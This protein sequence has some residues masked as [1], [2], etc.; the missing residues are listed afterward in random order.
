MQGEL[1]SASLVPQTPSF[2]EN[3]VPPNPL[4]Y[5]GEDLKW[6]TPQ[7]CHFKSLPIPRH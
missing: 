2:R 5:T 3:Y 6:D 1:R 4:L 7:G